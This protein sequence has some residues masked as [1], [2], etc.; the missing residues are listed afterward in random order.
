MDA[1]KLNLFLLT[2]DATL[3]QKTDINTHA[4][5]NELSSFQN[6]PL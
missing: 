1:A 4:T 2:E 5:V 6:L 3:T